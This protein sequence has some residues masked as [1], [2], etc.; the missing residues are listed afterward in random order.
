MSALTRSMKRANARRATLARIGG[1]TAAAVAATSAMSAVP[2][3]AAASS[4]T[5]CDTGMTGA[6]NAVAL[7]NAIDNMSSGDT[8]NITTVGACVVDMQDY[9]DAANRYFDITERTVTINGP[10][11]TGQSLASEQRIRWS[12]AAECSR[13]L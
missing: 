5:L 8:L 9:T 3:F 10:T 1:A 11:A 6:Q 12:G 13:W 4:V 7:W 2:A